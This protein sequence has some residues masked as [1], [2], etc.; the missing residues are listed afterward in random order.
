MPHYRVASFNAFAAQ[1]YWINRLYEAL[2]PPF[3]CLGNR[4]YLKSALIPQFQKGIQVVKDW[5][6]ELAY[7]LDFRYPSPFLTNLVRGAL[8]GSAF[9]RHASLHWRRARCLTLPHLPQYIR[10]PGI[11]MLGELLSFVDAS[12]EF[13]ISMGILSLQ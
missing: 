1:R 13:S 12:H 2:D 4:S 8:L 10:P 5:T 3:Y 11:F 7:T 9:D 6:Q